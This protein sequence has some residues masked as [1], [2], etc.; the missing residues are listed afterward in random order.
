MDYVHRTGNEC[1]FIS[2]PQCGGLLEAV[3]R[4]EFEEYVHDGEMDARQDELEAQ[5][6]L[7]DELFADELILI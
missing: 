4:K 6:D 3:S 7:E 5:W 2:R 1:A